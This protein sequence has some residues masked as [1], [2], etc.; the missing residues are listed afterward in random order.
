MSSPTSPAI[1]IVSANIKLFNSKSDN[2]SS[3]LN[4]PTPI[5]RNKNNTDCQN[6]PPP[7]PPKPNKKP[8][9][10]VSN[11]L[12]ISPSNSSTHFSIPNYNSNN[13]LPPPLPPTAPPRPL[14]RHATFSHAKTQFNNSNNTNTN[15]KKPLSASHTGSSSSSITTSISPIAAQKVGQH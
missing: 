5:T 15:H 2:E 12:D 10:P 3:T 4:K 1:G 14:S 11:R 8:T 13:L 7:L 9:L 6:V